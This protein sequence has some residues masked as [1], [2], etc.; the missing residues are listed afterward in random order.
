ML[1]SSLTSQEFQMGE[2]QLQEAKSRLSEVLRRAAAEGPQHI[3]VRGAPAGVVLSEADYRRLQRP[4]P[5]FVE[6]MRS[7][8]LVGMELDLEREQATTRDVDFGK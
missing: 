4:R 1:A 7:S 3:T 6:F 5:R 2:W 8:P